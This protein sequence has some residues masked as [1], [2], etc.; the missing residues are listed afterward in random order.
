MEP[1]PGAGPEPADAPLGGVQAPGDL[2]DRQSGEVPQK[3]DARSPGIVV[4][5][6]LQ[7]TIEC[8]QLLRPWLV[9]DPGLVEGQRLLAATPLLA[10]AAA[11]P[12]D[13]DSPHRFGRRREKVGPAVPGEVSVDEPQIGLVDQGGGLELRTSTLAAHPMPSD[14]PQLLVD[15]GDEVVRRAVVPAPESVEA[16]GDPPAPGGTVLHG[17]GAIQADVSPVS[18]PSEKIWRPT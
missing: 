18:N 5:E 8:Q 14:R 7:G 16:L 12:V 13:E 11:R 2:L 1:C 4:G 17:Q 10:A 3:H 6:A 15:D 9:T